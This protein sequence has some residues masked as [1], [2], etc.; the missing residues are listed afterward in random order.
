[1]RGVAARGA[2]L[3]ALPAQKT[4]VQWKSLAKRSKQE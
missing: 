3:A 2:G 1:M 4:S